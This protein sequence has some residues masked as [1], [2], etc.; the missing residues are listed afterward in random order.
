AT[1][2]TIQRLNSGFLRGRARRRERGRIIKVYELRAPNPERRTPNASWWNSGFLRGRA[3][4]R[5][6]GRIIKVYELRTPNPGRRTPNASWWNAEIWA[7]LPVRCAGISAGK[8]I[9]A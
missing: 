5:E 9:L 8:S 2:A 3:R 4:R 7:L 6:R 1:I